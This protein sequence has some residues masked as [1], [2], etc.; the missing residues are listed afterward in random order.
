M[1]TSIEKERK[2]K[3]KN[4]VFEQHIYSV[5]FKLTISELLVSVRNFASTKLHISCTLSL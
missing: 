3:D 1:K 2:S 4:I 5:F